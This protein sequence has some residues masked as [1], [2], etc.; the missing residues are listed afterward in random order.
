MERIK[1]I[2]ANGKLYEVFGQ[3][4]ETRNSWGHNGYLLIDGHEVSKNRVRYYNRTW[5][6]YRFQTAGRGA[7]WAYIEEL[8]RRALN[9]YREATGRARLSQSLKDGIYKLDPDIQAVQMV[10]D[11]L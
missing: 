1:R 10:Y 4:W 2:E 6:G 7:V 8:K 9:R 11:A 3:Y 5:E